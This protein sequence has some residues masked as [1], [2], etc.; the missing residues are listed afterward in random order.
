[1]RGGIMAFD[2]WQLFCERGNFCACLCG[3]HA[4]DVHHALIPNLKRFDKYVN[5]PRNLALVNHAQHVSRKFDNQH[6]RREFYR[7]NVARYGQEAMDEWI[8][9]LPAKLKY[10]LDFLR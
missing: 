1:M 7:Q 10:R 6:W 4:Q 9:S 8:N 3:C 2:K 5:D